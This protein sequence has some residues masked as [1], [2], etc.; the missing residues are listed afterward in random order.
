MTAPPCAQSLYKSPAPP[1]VSARES[2]AAR[3]V[4]LCEQTGALVAVLRSL[5]VPGVAPPRGYVRAVCKLGGY[6]VKPTHGATNNAHAAPRAADAAQPPSVMCVDRG[7]NRGRSLD[8]S[9]V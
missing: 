7:S 5:D 6:Q 8:G 2:C 3:V 4:L 9:P 1:F